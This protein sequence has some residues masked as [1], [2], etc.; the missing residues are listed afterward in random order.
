MNRVKK[1]FS[2]IKLML[3]VLVSMPLVSIAA[4]KKGSGV[5]VRQQSFFWPAESTRIQQ[6]LTSQKELSDFSLLLI[7][8]ADFNGDSRKLLKELAASGVKEQQLQLRYDLKARLPK[9]QKKTKKQKNSEIPAQLEVRI[10]WFVARIKQCRAD[11]FGC[12]NRNNLLRMA[13]PKE[14]VIAP[15]AKVKVDGISAIKALTE[16]RNNNPLES[17][18]GIGETAGD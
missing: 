12:A 7:P 10:E 14:L 17:R 9:R 16:M 18:S 3:M 1:R 2:L 13:K 5:E 15:G 8:T 11:E 4:E 6:F